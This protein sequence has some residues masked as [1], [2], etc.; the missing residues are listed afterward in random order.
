LVISTKTRR[1]AGFLLAKCAAVRAGDFARPLRCELFHFAAAGKSGRPGADGPDR[2]VALELSL[3]RARML[4]DWLHLVGRKR[5]RWMRC[6]GI[7]PPAASRIPVNG[8]STIR[9]TPACSATSPLRHHD[10]GPSCVGMDIMHIQM[11][12][13]FVYLTVVLDWYRRST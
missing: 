7:E 2:G 9:C 11:A 12:R 13:G 6:V 5:A 4:R 10:A 1:L 3:G 8:I